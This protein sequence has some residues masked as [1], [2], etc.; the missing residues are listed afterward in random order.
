MH[1][2]RAVNGRD[3]A[4]EIIKFEE[5]ILTCE[6]N[7]PDLLSSCYQNFSKFSEHWVAL[8]KKI[9]NYDQLIAVP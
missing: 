4:R 2:A 6:I 7:L 3:S 8:K 9:I 1:C 5:N